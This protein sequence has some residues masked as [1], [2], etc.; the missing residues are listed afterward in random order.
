MEWKN[1]I[2]QHTRAGH[3]IR[4]HRKNHFDLVFPLV[5]LLKNVASPG[6]RWTV[7]LSEDFAVSKRDK[8]C[9]TRRA[10]SGDEIV[11]EQK[12]NTA[13]DRS[14][15][16]EREGE[17]GMF[18]VVKPNITAA[19]CPDAIS[20]KI[21]IT[22]NN[23]NNN[24]KPCYTVGCLVSCRWSVCLWI[25]NWMEGDY[26]KHYDCANGEFPYR[27]IATILCVS[28][29]NKCAHQTFDSRSSHARI[30]PFTAL[31]LPF[32]LSI[33]FLWYCCLYVH[34]E[35]RMVR[36]H[37]QRDSLLC[38]WWD[39]SFRCIHRNLRTK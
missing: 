2:F 32:T 31:S 16:G 30:L 21:P 20:H 11:E 10:F 24:N 7:H 13:R 28:V 29:R 19:M 33:S 15:G 17:S 6:F 22:S 39:V 12:Y 14:E 18:F 9:A 36:S 34:F 1:A 3:A 8:P 5:R 25:V 23:N 27:K 37:K 4:C 38:D 26:G 35:M